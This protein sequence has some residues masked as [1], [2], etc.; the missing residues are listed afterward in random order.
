MSL[1]YKDQKNL[2]YEAT[3]KQRKDTDNITIEF[4]S[5]CGKFGTHESLAGYS[6][7]PKRL[8]EILHDRED[9]KDKELI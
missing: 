9:I 1:L 7:T 3:I 5:D 4:H 8:L 2:I 6:L